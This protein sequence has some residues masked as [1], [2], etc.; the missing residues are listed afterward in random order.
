MNATLLHVSPFAV[1]A[2]E[3]ETIGVNDL[4]TIIVRITKTANSN[5]KLES[6]KDWTHE[7]DLGDWIR[8][9][10]KHGLVPASFPGGKPAVSFDYK[11][12]WGGDGKYDR[13]D[14]LTTRIQATVINVKPNGNLVLE[15]K[16]DVSFGEEDYTITLIGT[17]RSVDVTPQNTIL[18]TQVA[19]LN[20]DVIDRGALRDA[21]R[22]GWLM[23][24]LDLLRPF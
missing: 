10:D 17:C 12:D 14:S 15:A 9:S 19:N 13:K 22:R 8:L 21:T 1:A 7:W 4:I 20:V 11:N 5:S 16:N 3:P 24:G 23:R 6:K 18:S 2:P